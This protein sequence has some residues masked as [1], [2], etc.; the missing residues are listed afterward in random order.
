MTNR[1]TRTLLSGCVFAAVLLSMASPSEAQGF[2]SPLVGFNVGG[3]AGC[4]TLSG[5]KDKTLNVG[6]AFGSLGRVFGVEEE[7]VYAKDFFGQQP[8]QTSNVLTVMTRLIAGPKIKVARPYLSAGLG[9][10]K[11]RVELTGASLLSRS[12]NALGWDVGGGLVLSLTRHVGVRGDIRQIRAFEHVDLG[13]VSLSSENL[14]FGRA[15]AS[16]MLTF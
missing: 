8:G 12:N 2:V 5:C 7:V 15:S 11:A 3:D 10:I 14:H 16:L 9:L 1:W 13:P 6:L 4:Q